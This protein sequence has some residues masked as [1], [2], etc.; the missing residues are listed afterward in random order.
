MF[1]GTA[2][3]SLVCDDLRGLTEIGNETPILLALVRLVLDAQ[4]PGR[5]DRNEGGGAVTEPVRFAAHPRDGHDASEQAAR[6][7][8]AKRDN[9]R[10]LDDR[11][12]LI[13]PPFAALDLV[14]VGAFV[15]AALAAHLVLEVLDRVGD[16]SVAAC[17]AGSFQ[18][19]VENTPGRPD[20]GQ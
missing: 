9:R 20:E 8:G 13:E 19:R 5:M 1:R 18:R 3:R 14:G 6:R 10:R 7:S 11:A 2:L 4:Q 12:L 17:N 15:E 16:E